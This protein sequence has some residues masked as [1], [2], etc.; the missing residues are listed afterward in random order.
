MTEQDRDRPQP[1]DVGAV[2]RA[3]GKR[4]AGLDVE[5]R[6]W[7]VSRRF[8][9][10]AVFG[11]NVEDLKAMAPPAPKIGGC[12]L[13]Q[14]TAIDSFLR[15]PKRRGPP[16][17]RAEPVPA[18]AAARSDADDSRSDSYTA[19]RPPRHAHRSPPPPSAR[20]RRAARARGTRAAPM[21]ARASRR[22]AGGAGRRTSCRCA[23]RDGAAGARGRA[24]RRSPRCA[25]SMPAPTARARLLV[26]LADG[27]T[28]EACCCRAT[29]CACRARSAARS[30]ACSA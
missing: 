7:A 3:G 27:Q 21:G 22:T 4:T 19:D 1:V 5:R 10:L 28:V 15:R 16:V 30:A 23:L 18:R 13:C 11:R 8:A 6:T 9:C 20:P 26:G 14:I 17:T 12:P 25:P 24:A 2:F 29:A